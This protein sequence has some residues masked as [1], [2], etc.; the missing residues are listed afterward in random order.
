MKCI[1]HLLS[2]SCENTAHPD[3]YEEQNKWYKVTLPGAQKKSQVVPVLDK[4]ST[5]PWGSME[6]VDV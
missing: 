5:R 6:G 1:L 3:E 4:L 2:I